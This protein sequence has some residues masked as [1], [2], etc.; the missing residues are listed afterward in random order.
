MVDRVAAVSERLASLG[1][2]VRWRG[3]LASGELQLRLGY[4]GGSPKGAGV[5]ASQ[6][7]V[8]AV[9]ADVQPPRWT[10]ALREAFGQVRAAFDPAGVLV[11]R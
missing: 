3:Q 8:A 11:G 10:P 5:M 6:Q 7:Q 9:L 1:L 2:A 4:P